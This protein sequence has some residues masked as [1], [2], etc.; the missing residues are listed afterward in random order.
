ML[1]ILLLLLSMFL[2]L[3]SIMNKLK[4]PDACIPTLDGSRNPLNK[5]SYLQTCLTSL[6]WTVIAPNK[7]EI[8]QEVAPLDASV[9]TLVPPNFV[10]ASGDGKEIPC[11]DWLLYARWPFFRHLFTTGMIESTSKRADLDEL[12]FET[13]L[14]LVH[15]LY[16]NEVS[17]FANE[18]LAK[19]LYAHAQRFNF[20]DMSTPP[21]ATLPAFKKLF[22]MCRRIFDQTLTEDVAAQLLPL[23]VDYATPM[24]LERIT[25]C[26]NM[27]TTEVQSDYKQLVADDDDD[28]DLVNF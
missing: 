25:N 21:Q 20:V 18:E 19:D 3:K 1:T 8:P 2:Y 9:A 5:G 12:K 23:A 7:S 11:H 14:P 28:D 6:Y 24:Q 22:S 17:D 16:T 4:L 15:F 26:I 13:L 10:L 27:V